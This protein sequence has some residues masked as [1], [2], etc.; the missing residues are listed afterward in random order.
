MAGEI[1]TSQLVDGIL[2][3]DAAGRL[4]IAND[5]FGSAAVADK[6]TG[7][8]WTADASG[9]GKFQD[10]IWTSAE[11]S[12]DVIQVSTGTLSQAQLFALMATQITAVA[13][14]AGSVLKFIDG[15][16]FYD[17]GGTAYT[18][19]A[20]GDDLGLRYTDGAGAKV[21]VDVDTAG[22]LS[23]VADVTKRIEAVTG[24][25]VCV[26]GAALVW[27]NVGANEWTLGNGVVR[28][29]IRY[30]VHATGF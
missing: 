9:R 3:A 7:D 19:T 29:A 20:G 1:I 27:D 13:G 26:A 21:A 16:L 12:T 14:V 23:A 15:M 8:C 4:K 6:F 10:G 2:S 11:M 17:Y 24:D 5:F 18:V 30:S 28:W 22:L 25:L